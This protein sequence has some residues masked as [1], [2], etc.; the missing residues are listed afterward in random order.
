MGWWLA[1]NQ[2]LYGDPLGWGVF[3]ASPL[4]PIDQRPITAASFLG[5]L[6]AQ[7]TPGSDFWR[8]LLFG[9]GQM[10]FGQ[11]LLLGAAFALTA[12]GLGGLL[13]WAWTHWDDRRAWA[14]DAVIAA[15][16]V[17][18]VVGGIVRYSL[19][20]FGPNGRYLFPALPLIALGLVCGWRALLPRAA[21]VPAAAA[22]SLGLLGLAVFTPPGLFLPTYTLANRLDPA[23][24]AALG[25]NQRV[26]FGGQIELVRADLTPERPALG[27][28][29]RARLVWRAI[30]DVPRSYRAFV[31]VV[32]LDGAMAGG[33]DRVPGNG[34]ASTGLWRRGD[35]V[36]DDFEVTLR[37][38]T[39]PGLYRVVSSFY[40]FPDLVRLPAAGDRV[41]SGD[42]T[43]L[44]ELKLLPPVAWA[45]QPIA[46]FGTEIALARAEI[47]PTLARFDEPIEVRLLWLASR[48]PSSDYTVSIQLLGPDRS[49]VAQHDSPPLDGA[50]PTSSWDAGDLVPDTVVVRV[51]PG[52]P[53][54]LTVTAVVY[55]SSD[56]ERLPVGSGDSQVLGRLT[57]EPPTAR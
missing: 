21:R 20:F 17:L 38:N 55:R 15:T 50:L 7:W 42:V 14:A 44:R 16:A 9:A 10:V 18:L 6:V 22:A 27:D 56:G 3:S 37:P 39:R 34:A 19:T 33:V 48:Q 12:T 1:R 23:E 57:M 47:A 51:P 2:A 31:H 26:T 36:Y 11:A 46:Q 13:T 35:V 52:A 4:W 54:T 40:R 45:G 5:E 53:S 24:A 28:P 30:Q 41:I 49:L 25:A 32:G 29:I 43:V 8:S